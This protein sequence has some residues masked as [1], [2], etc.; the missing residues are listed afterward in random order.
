MPRSTHIR[1]ALFALVLLEACSSDAT[2]PAEFPAD[3]AATYTEVRNCRLSV[4]HDME[5]VRVLASPSALAPYMNRTDPF[6]LGAIV[7]KEQYDRLDTSCSGTILD[8]SVMV[9]VAKGNGPDLQDW[10]WQHVSADHSVISEDIGRCTR[11]H[12][13]CANQGVGYA[14]TCEQP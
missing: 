13:D 1:V 11:C 10:D 6:P 14:G 4:D 5:N 9:R 8:Y 3:Y 2:A 7:L 12:K